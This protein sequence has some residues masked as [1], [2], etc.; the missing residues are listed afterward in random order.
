M[1]KFQNGLEQKQTEETNDRFSSWLVVNQVAQFGM[2]NRLPAHVLLGKGG[3][4]G[5]IILTMNSQVTSVTCACRSS[6]GND[7]P[8]SLG[9]VLHGALSS[10]NDLL[11]QRAPLFFAFASGYECAR[12]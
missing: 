3:I 4:A 2:M 11:A 5:E 9:R 7:P 8:S 12:I 1:H 10:V 6:F